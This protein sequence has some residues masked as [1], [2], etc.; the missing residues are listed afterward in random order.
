MKF[1]TLSMWQLGHYLR[2]VPNLGSILCLGLV[3]SL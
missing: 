3:G 1:V 2:E